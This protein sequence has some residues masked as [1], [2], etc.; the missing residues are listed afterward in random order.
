MAPL[1]E[2]EEAS[3]EPLLAEHQ[4]PRG[5]K[6]STLTSVTPYILVT[7]FCER[8]TYYGLA[9][10]LVLFM[11]SRLNYSNADADVQFSIWSGFCYVTPLV[12]GWLADTYLGRYKTILILSTLYLGGLVLMV[13]GAIPGHESEIVIYPAL[14][15]IAMGTGGIKPNVSTFG[16]DQ[17]NDNDPEDAK[18]KGAFF[19]WFYWSINL[20][21]LVSY[22][23]VAYVAQ[24]GVTGLGGEEWGFFL[25][26]MIPAISMGLAILAFIVGTPKFI[27]KPPGG[28]VLGEACSM[29]YEAAV[30]RRNVVADVDYWLFRASVQHGGNYEHK[31][32]VGVSYVM[33]LMPV[34]LLMIPYWLCYS[35]M[36]TTFQNQGC[37]MDLSIGDDFEIPVS[38][39]NLFDTV[40]ILMLAP[41]FV[42]VVFPYFENR[43]MPLT[44]LQKIGIG[45][46]F[47][48]LAMGTAGVLEIV[49]KQHTHDEEYSGLESFLNTEN[50]ISACKDK[51][52]Y[53]PR[54]FQDYYSG[55]GDKPQ[56]C[57]STCET[58]DGDK[59]SIDCIECDPV[60][61]VSSVS[62]FW[63]VPQ[64]LLVGTSEILSSVVAMEL[65]YN[66]CPSNMRSITAALNLLTTALGSWACIPLVLIV[67]ADP[68]N[69]WMPDDLNEGHLEYVFA[70]IVII[71]LVTLAV[72]CKWASGYTYVKPEDLEAIDDEDHVEV[73][74]DLSNLR[75]PE[76]EPEWHA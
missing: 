40:A 50:E 18:E 71:M 51:S 19:N 47:S 62:I 6:A 75:D 60:P 43:N 44:M 15:I 12:G 41:V 69:K 29:V 74:K 23:A 70:V 10:S 57:W 27:I 37:Q 32:V 9:G 46:G 28:S 16:A 33:K 3:T 4:L 61:V 64:F 56:N 11:Q 72:Y 55:D 22:T 65:F 73:V 5:K 8:L 14:Y 54:V 68:D 49:R 2:D 21:A 63:Q 42:K 45:F 76:E 38:A 53:D 34:L 24:Y 17:F 39:L 48:M 20:G 52:D 1:R 35:Q 58:M 7:E 66:Q 13:F 30:T 59:L 26:F 36:S 31:F 25:G 67:N